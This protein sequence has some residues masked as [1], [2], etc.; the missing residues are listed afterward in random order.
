MNSRR[1]VRAGPQ[2][3]VLVLLLAPALLAS[4][5]DAQVVAPPPNS[6]AICFADYQ[7]APGQARPACATSAASGA[8]DAYYFEG[9]R[10]PMSLNVNGQ[11]VV[12]KVAC[13]ENCAHT[14]GDTST[15]TYQA[16][17][18]GAA[19]T[20]VVFPDD[21]RENGKDAVRDRAGTYNSTWRT[22]AYVLGAQGTLVAQRDFHTALVNSF[23]AD[24]G[25]VHPGEHHTFVAAGFDDTA[26]LNLTLE[27]RNGASWE[28]VRLEGYGCVPQGSGLICSGRFP[29]SEAVHVAACGHDTVRCYRA[30]MSGT[31]KDVETVYYKVAPAEITGIVPVVATPASGSQVERTTNLTVALPLG[32]PGGDAAYRPPLTPDHV[33]VDPVLGLRALRLTVLRTDAGGDV[34]VDQVPLTFDATLQRWSGTWT[35]PKDAATNDSVGLVK[36]ALNLSQGRDEYNN[37]VAGARLAVYDVGPATLDVRVAQGLNELPRTEEGRVA[38]RITYHNGENFTD[39]TNA[40]PLTGCFLHVTRATGNDCTGATNAERVTLAFEDGLW[41]ARVRYP[42]DYANLDAH[43]FL[44]TKSNDTWNNVVPATVPADFNVV[45][46]SPHVEFWTVF[47]GARD[48]VIVRDDDTLYLNAKITFGDGAA[49]NNTMVPNPDG[50]APFLTA[51]VEKHTLD[52]TL[53]TTVPVTLRGETYGPYWSG[54]IRLT[55]NN[56]QTPLGTWS[57]RMDVLDNLTT[58]NINHTSFARKLIGAPLAYREESSPFDTEIGNRTRVRFSILRAG[59]DD[60]PAIDMGVTM[61]VALY[62]YDAARKVL[63]GD[64]VAKLIPTYSDVFHQYVAELQIPP[65][66]FAGTFVFVVRGGDRDGNL[67]L[68]DGVSRPFKTYAT[69]RERDVLTQPAPSL[70]RGDEAAVVFDGLVGDQDPD[71]LGGNPVVHVDYFNPNSKQWEGKAYDARVNSTSPNIVALFPITIDT[72]VGVYRFVLAGRQADYHLISA[73][74]SNFTVLPA[75]VGRVLVEAPPENATKGVSFGFSFERQAGDVVYQRTVYYEGRVVP[76]PGASL[77]SEESLY[78]GSWVVPFDQPAGKYTLRFEGADRYGNHI[79]VT[80]PPVEVLSAQLTG[81]IIGSPARNVARGTTASV[82]FGITYPSGA[83]YLDPNVPKVSVVNESGFVAEAAVKREG[84]T[85][86]ATWTPGPEADATGEYSFEIAGAASA[87]NTFPTLRSASFRVTPGTLARSPVVD[88]TADNTRGDRVTLQVPFVAGDQFAQFSLEYYGTTSDASGQVLGTRDPLSVT[89]LPHTL[90]PSTGRYVATFL[91]DVQTAPGSY[92]IVMKAVDKAGNDVLAQS[93]PFLL[94]T[95]TVVIGWDTTLASNAL[96]EGQPFKASFTAKYA[97]S[98]L[99]MDDAHGRPSVVLLYRGAE[100]NGA[101]RPSGIRPDVA[102]ENGHWVLS[103][104]APDVLPAGEYI[105]SVG[106][107]DLNGNQILASQSNAVS[108]DPA[109]SNS[110]AKVGPKLLPGP[111]LGLVVVGLAALAVL[112]GRRA[113]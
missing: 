64:P 17:W 9:Q 111:E 74:S 79:D 55:T 51:F 33:P 15:Q 42:R 81:K 90:D 65:Q 110:L 13:V 107:A 46:G 34:Q 113:R 53:V 109:F 11:Q 104:P 12:F 82:L 8:P 94:R 112:L 76:L 93:R 2:L 66:L 3:A 103:W 96:A 73:V 21:F 23:L 61:N 45:T 26:R 75:D 58:P 86:T 60:S 97:K 7:L 22:W 78:N 91:T 41:V 52:G 83:F 67:L 71:G 85:F 80:L 5:A 18:S 43:R 98:G 84:L 50:D 38:L 49:L 72:N 27:R 28:P 57:V 108:Y 102:Y 48:D 54:A 39:K 56:S 68:A 35:V 24:D 1:H 63:V 47:Q 100:T 37:R 88:A 105:F 101:Q 10:V 32:Y 89:L 6:Y 59:M 31:G 69:P 62:R 20:S 14:N 40:S 29:P 70:V 30:V 19:G 16:T 4:S 99:V 25:A 36:Y 77:V 106:G 44:L 92:R 87:G 95:S